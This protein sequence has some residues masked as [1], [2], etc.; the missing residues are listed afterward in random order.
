MRAAIYPNGGVPPGWVVMPRFVC[1]QSA[2]LDTAKRCLIQLLNYSKQE[3]T[4]RR[5][6]VTFGASPT[7]ISSVLVTQIP[8]RVA[9]IARCWF[10]FAPA[11]AG[12]LRQ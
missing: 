11:I 1:N 4:N 6:I 3:G 7:T 2:P 9:A 12:S 8:C 10:R 5:I